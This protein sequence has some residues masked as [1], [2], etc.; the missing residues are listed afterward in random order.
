MKTTHQLA[1]EM[2][3]HPSTIWRAIKSGKIKAT[4]TPGGHYRILG[5]KKE[6]GAGGVIASGKR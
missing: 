3:V 6:G 5:N 2:G 4:R 1:K